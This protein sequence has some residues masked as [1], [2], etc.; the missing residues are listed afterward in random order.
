MATFAIRN[1]GFTHLFTARLEGGRTELATGANIYIADQCN[2]SYSA[3]RIPF[4][5][6]VDPFPFIVPQNPRI[7]PPISSTIRRA[8]D[9]RIESDRP[10]D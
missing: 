4:R 9:Y 1:D 5:M 6:S 3:D 8:I 10:T 2:I 7:H